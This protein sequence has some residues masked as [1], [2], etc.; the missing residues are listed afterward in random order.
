[1]TADSLLCWDEVTLYW[2]VCQTALLSWQVIDWIADGCRRRGLDEM[3]GLAAPFYACAGV[4]QVIQA[5]CMVSVFLPTGPGTTHHTYYWIPTILAM[6]GI[7]SLRKAFRFT[8]CIEKPLDPFVV[9]AGLEDEYN[10]SD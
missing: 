6:I 4:L 8:K 3:P 2:F 9:A 1:M 10:Y 5:F 7:H